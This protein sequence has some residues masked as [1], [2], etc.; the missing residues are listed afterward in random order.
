VKDESVD[1]DANGMVKVE[2][3]DEHGK[4][5]IIDESLYNFHRYYDPSGRLKYY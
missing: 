4:Q 1:D 3:I 2:P 5:N